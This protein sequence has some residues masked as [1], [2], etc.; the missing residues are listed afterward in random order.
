MDEPDDD[1]IRA[2]HFTA[3]RASM[4]CWKCGESTQVAA[5]WIDHD[6]SGEAF[7]DGPALLSYIGPLDLYTERQVLA[8]APWMRMAASAT[9]DTVYLANYCTQCDA[10]QGDFLVHGVDG[11]FFPQ[12]EADI[13]R[14][15]V[16]A[17]EGP[18]R[19]EAALCQSSWMSRITP[20]AK[21]LTQEYLELPVGPV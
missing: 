10:L 4:P 8:L 3:L 7:D 19:A 6:L 2:E 12:S 18:L 1:A 9:A 5:V 11:P 21:G 17:G 15:E 13:A 14:I 20:E 16:V